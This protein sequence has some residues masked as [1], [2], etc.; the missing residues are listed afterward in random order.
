MRKTIIWYHFSA[1][2][3]ITG[4]ILECASSDLELMHIFMPPGPSASTHL[5]V[6]RTL[7]FRELP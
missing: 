2:A 7:G 6:M 4:N 1:M 5:L 3:A